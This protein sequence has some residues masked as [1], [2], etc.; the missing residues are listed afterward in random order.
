MKDTKKAVRRGRPALYGDK[1]TRIEILVPREW[2]E[3]AQRTAAKTGESL[4]E[5]YRQWIDGG[6]K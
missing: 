4:S 1:L 3:E 6:R 2:H 5:I